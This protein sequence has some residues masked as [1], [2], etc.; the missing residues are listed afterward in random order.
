MKSGVDLVV[1]G[2]WLIAGWA[3]DVQQG[4]GEI[5]A[6]SRTGWGNAKLP[7]VLGRDL[8]HRRPRKKITSI[9]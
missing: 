1:R 4:A 9:Q 7:G 8:I 3:A 6:G 2:D 5:H